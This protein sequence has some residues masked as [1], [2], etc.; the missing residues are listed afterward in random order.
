MLHYCGL[1]L[2]KGGMPPYWFVFD[3]DETL[4]HVSPY[5]VLLCTFFTAEFAK[6]MKREGKATPE[7]IREPLAKAYEEFFRACVAAETSAHP[8]GIL[9]P[10]M[11]E[12][13]QRIGKLK[14]EGNV[15]GCLIYSNNRTRRIL[16]FIRDF[17]HA[18]LGRDDLIG[19]IAHARDKRRGEEGSAKRVATIL[20]F[21]RDGPYEAAGVK[22]ED[23]FFFDDIDHADISAKIGDRYIRVWP[24]EYRVNTDRIVKLYMESLRKAG[25]LTNKPLMQSFIRHIA[26]SCFIKDLHENDTNEEFKEHITKS[27]H[28]QVAMWNK[29]FG[30]H[31]STPPREANDSLKPILAR[32]GS[33]KGGRRRTQRKRRSTT[34]GASQRRAVLA[35]RQSRRLSKRQRCS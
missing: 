24:Y 21:L 29:S 30:P 32:L 1:E 35:R 31:P 18:I 7:E 19:D 16:E 2:E 23:I 10:G 27:I 12:L 15:G 34:S 3:M 4:T 26:G 33:L 14:D 8:L 5:R 20:K 13:F 25:F 22:E 11:A 9:R 28:D 6:A 17:I